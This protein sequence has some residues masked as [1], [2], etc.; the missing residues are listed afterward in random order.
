MPKAQRP[1]PSPAHPYRVALLARAP[2]HQQRH[3]H[4][5]NSGIQPAHDACRSRGPSGPQAAQS[6]SGRPRRQRRRRGGTSTGAGAS[7]PGGIPAG[8]GHRPKAAM[9]EFGQASRR[10]IWSQATNAVYGAGRSFGREPENRLRRPEKRRARV[11]MVR[12][13]T[14]LAASRPRSFLVQVSHRCLQHRS[15]R[16]SC[17]A[18]ILDR[19]G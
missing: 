18:P 14:E 13:W 3:D 12:S 2:I 19:S 10:F 17:L 15:Q 16:A 5:R 7:G 4:H 8:R 6:S 11:E 1:Q 9:Q